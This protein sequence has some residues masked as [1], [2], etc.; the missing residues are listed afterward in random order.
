ML[1]VRARSV[2]SSNQVIPAPSNTYPSQPKLGIVMS[3]INEEAFKKPKAQDDE[4]L[5]EE[6]ETLLVRTLGFL[7]ML[8][9]SP[10]SW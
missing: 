7:R 1:L 5:E 9:H 2:R 6:A 4:G 10:I 8:Y 3:V